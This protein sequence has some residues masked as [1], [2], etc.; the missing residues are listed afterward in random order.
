MIVGHGLARHHFWR[1]YYATII[2][3]FKP[4]RLLTAEVIEAVLPSFNIATHPDQPEMLTATFFGGD[5]ALD[6]AIAE[7]VAVGAE[8]GKILS[9]ARS[10][11]WGEPFTVNVTPGT[12]GN[13]VVTPLGGL[14]EAS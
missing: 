9:I 10:I 12:A 7:L 5:A 4:Q 6:T 1:D 8:R 14:S 2:V 13:T 3:T 11:D